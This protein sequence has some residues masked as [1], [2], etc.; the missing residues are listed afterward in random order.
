M[1]AETTVSGGIDNAEGSE[2]A[3]SLYVFVVEVSTYFDR[4]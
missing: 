1:E 3:L 4:V 2:D